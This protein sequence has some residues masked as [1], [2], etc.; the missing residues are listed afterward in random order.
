MHA[1]QLVLSKIYL[2]VRL[3][4]CHFLFSY[5]YDTSWAVL[6][7][8][9]ADKSS[10]NTK[11]HKVLLIQTHLKTSRLGHVNDMQDGLDISLISLYL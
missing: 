10:F 7:Y 2:C 8:R 9:L 3:H 11:L 5:S 1:V 4:K 6:Q